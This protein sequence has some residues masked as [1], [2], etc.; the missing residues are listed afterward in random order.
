MI[1]QFLRRIPFCVQVALHDFHKMNWSHFLIAILFTLA[2][3]YV[4]GGESRSAYYYPDSSKLPKAR[5]LSAANV[6]S[7]LKSRAQDIQSIFKHETV[8]DYVHDPEDGRE[9]SV[10]TATLAVKSR[11]PVLVLEELEGHLEDI[12]C[13]DSQISLLFDSI[14]KVDVIRKA[15]GT[16]SNFVVV[17]SHNGC[18]SDGERATHR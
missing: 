9:D 7:R 1:L 2:V 17:T 4:R 15:I 13:S 11:S 18:N 8:F 14:D 6:C 3:E 10:F 5:R 12:V 16:T